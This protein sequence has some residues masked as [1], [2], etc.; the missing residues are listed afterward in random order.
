MTAGLI[1]THC[2]LG[3]EAFD[4]DR[5]AVIARAHERGVEHALVVGQNPGENERVLELVAEDGHGGFLLAA[6]GQHPD[7]PDEA[8]AA[9]SLE[10]ARRNAARLSGLGEVG[11]DRFKVKDDDGRADRKSVV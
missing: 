2:H 8:A 11:L 10:I 5:A 9:R 6:C 3:D 4:A 7:Q 1:D